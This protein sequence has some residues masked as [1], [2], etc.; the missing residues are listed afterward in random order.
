M[1]ECPRCLGNGKLPQFKH[2]E[3]GLCFLCEGTGEVSALK[4][5]TFFNA[6]P[7]Q[8]QGPLVLYKKEKVVLEGFGECRIGKYPDGELVAQ[9]P[10]VD[11][12]GDPVGE[13]PIFFRIHNKQVVVNEDL[14]CAGHLRIKSQLRDALQKALKV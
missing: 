11:Y 8:E 3:N 13:I 14:V 12:N 7:T 6:K 4:A 1:Y 9:V 5:T 10:G 2:I